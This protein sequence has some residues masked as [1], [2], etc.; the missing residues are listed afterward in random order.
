MF[1]PS[2]ALYK[3]KYDSHQQRVK[4]H[5]RAYHTLYTIH[6]PDATYYST[7]TLRYDG[8]IKDIAMIYHHSQRRRSTV[9][10]S[11]RTLAISL[12]YARKSKFLNSCV[13]RID[14]P[15]EKHGTCGLGCYALLLSFWPE[16]RV[17]RTFGE[18]VYLY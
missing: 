2:S 13:T 6:L 12:T 9:G 4:C 1:T 5:S 11:R 15:H 17:A 3:A 10:P 18:P 16:A 14:M 8:L 7:L